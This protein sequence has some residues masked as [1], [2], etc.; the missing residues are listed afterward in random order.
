MTDEKNVLPFKVSEHQREDR[1]FYST[2]LDG[3]L[4]TVSPD[5]LVKE[6]VPSWPFL[7]LAINPPPQLGDKGRKERAASIISLTCER[8]PSASPSKFGLV[9]DTQL[10]SASK[11]ASSDISLP[12]IRH[13]RT[14]LFAYVAT[15]TVSMKWLRSFWSILCTISSLF[16]GLCSCRE[17]DRRGK[18]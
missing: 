17:S 11:A 6:K 1:N 13:V 3:K 7:F 12:A 2:G 9:R 10:D 4:K 15:A 16:V 5:E 18:R 14:A 8:T